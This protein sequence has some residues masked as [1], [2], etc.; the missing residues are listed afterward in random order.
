[1]QFTWREIVTAIHGMLFG[2]FFLMACFGVLV[3]L[4]RSFG[5]QGSLEVT[6]QVHRRERIF[7]I[8]MVMVGW[9]AVLSGAYLVYPWYRAAVPAGVT[10]L[11]EYPQRL[12]M[13]DPHTAG[14]HTLGMEW[15]EHVAWMAP[16]LMTMVAWVMMK[17]EDAGEEHRRLRAMVSGFA[18]AAFLA[19]G[20]AA[21][22]G[23]WINKKAP[24]T[25]GPVITLSQDGK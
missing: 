5:A 3:L 25:G 20:V 6:E 17:Y 13:S 23:A 14:W 18:L 22:F 10:N 11:T 1:M 2:G 8:V 12:L 9:A 21:E 7:L 4:H 15:K 24:V 19:G 16:M